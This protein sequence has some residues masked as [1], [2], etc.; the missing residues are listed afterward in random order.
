MKLATTIA[1][2]Q[3]AIGQGVRMEPIELGIEAT[4]ARQAMA[5]LEGSAAQ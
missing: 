1:A 4:L 3:S 2:A 5:R